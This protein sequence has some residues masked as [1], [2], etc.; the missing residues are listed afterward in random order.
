MLCF[1]NIDA[2]TNDIEGWDGWRVWKR[3]WNQGVISANILKHDQTLSDCFQSFS[4]S[5]G[6]HQFFYLVQNLF[7]L[8]S[9]CLVLPFTD[10]SRSVLELGAKSGNITRGSNYCCAADPNSDGR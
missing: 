4:V 5:R 2:I 1:R 6:I 3:L 10:G 8:M 9:L 7:D